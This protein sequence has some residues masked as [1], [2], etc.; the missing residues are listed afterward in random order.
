MPV[1]AVKM[2]GMPAVS[3]LRTLRLDDV[4]RKRADF[5]APRQDQLQRRRG[6]VGDGDG[7][8]CDGLGLM[9]TLR[10]DVA[11]NTLG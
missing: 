10:D 7:D 1:P 2:G 8:V 11:L 4:K 3:E 6:Q 5:G 9:D